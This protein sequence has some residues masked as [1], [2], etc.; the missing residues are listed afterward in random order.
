MERT[1]EG[2]ELDPQ[3]LNWEAAAV[4][5]GVILM[6]S[7]VSGSG[8][9]THDSSVTLANLLPGIA[10]YRDRFYQD[11]L[12]QCSGDHGKRLRAESKTM[13]QPFGG[14]RQHLNAQLARRRAAQLEHVHLAKIFA[15]MG[16]AE[17]AARQTDVVPVASARMLCQIDCRLTTVWHAV[18]DGSLEEAGQLLGEIKDLLQRAI[19]CGAVIDPW[20][21][22][23][24]DAHFSLF[25]ALENS[26]RDH[27]ADELVALMEQIFGLYSKVWS[28]AA[29]ADETLLCSRLSAQFYDEEIVWQS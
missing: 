28:A 27:R 29:V 22:L 17:A 1:E 26:I 5:A 25:P 8:P 3:E 7:G 12:E 13:R 6:A 11:L 2:N 4:L 16:Y 20:N 9:D 15:R 19:E 18:S 23:G 14:A 10:S 24:F 21:I